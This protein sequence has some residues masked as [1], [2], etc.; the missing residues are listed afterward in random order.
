MDT[1]NASELRRWASRC[2]NDAADKW[3]TADDRE[4]LLKMAKALLEL[5]D[6]A[7]WLAGRRKKVLAAN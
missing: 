6:N 2:Q 7:D 1:L 4:R 5:A 3:C